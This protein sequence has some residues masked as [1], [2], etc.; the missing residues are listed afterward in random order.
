MPRARHRA[1]S[2]GG[3][4]IGVRVVRDASLSDGAAAGHDHPQLGAYPHAAHRGP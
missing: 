3:H 4:R 1:T 2:G